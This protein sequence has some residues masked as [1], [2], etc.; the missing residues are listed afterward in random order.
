M[1]H[2]NLQIIPRS[3]EAWQGDAM[4]SD[5]SPASAHATMSEQTRQVGRMEGQH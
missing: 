3:E 2:R 4:A 5:L 1:L